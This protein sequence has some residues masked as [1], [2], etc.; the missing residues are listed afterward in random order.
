MKKIL[1]MLDR[2]VGCKACEIACAAEHAK[3]D[4][5]VEAVKER[6]RPISRISVREG[7]KLKD[8]EREPAY[9][10]S[11]ERGREKNVYPIRCR[12]CEDPKC[13]EACMSGALEKKEDGT[14]IH[15]P[16]ECVGCWMCI[17]SCPYGA[18][19]RDVKNQIVLKC[20]LCEDRETP[21]CVEACKTQ[22]IIY[23]C[24]EEDLTGPVVEEVAQGVK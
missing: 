5:I 17:M 1:I 3:S 12:H 16:D 18:L 22:A 11:R 10:Q 7:V 24:D 14:V 4:D 19:I 8:E 21:A 23:Q 6:P 15:K 20:D 13:V 2:C 9:G